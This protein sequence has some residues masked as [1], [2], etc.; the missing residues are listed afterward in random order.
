MAQIH[1]INAEIRGRTYVASW[2][3]EDERLHLST[4]FTSE[5]IALGK[6]DPTVEALKLLKRI[7]RLRNA[8]AAAAIRAANDAGGVAALSHG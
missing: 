3:I 7:I 4:V 6:K 2:Y 8:A 1:L 5:S